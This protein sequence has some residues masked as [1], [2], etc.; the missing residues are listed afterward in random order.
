[1]NYLH[2]KITLHA[3]SLGKSVL[4]LDIEAQ[5]KRDI[6]LL[7]FFNEEI[8]KC[9]T[10]RE[11]KHGQIGRFPCKIFCSIHRTGSCRF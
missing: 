4:L 3:L 1:M 11:F 6:S 9:P 7:Y 10:P 2:F 5:I 8:F